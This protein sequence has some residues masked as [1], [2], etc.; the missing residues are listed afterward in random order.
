MF[1]SSLER[2]RHQ[3][4]LKV[5]WKAFELQPREFPPSPEQKAAKERMIQRSWPRVEAM[6]REIYGLQLQRPRLG[7]DTRDAHVAAKATERWNQGDAYHEAL[8]VAYW[9]EGRDIGDREVLTSLAQNLGIDPEAFEAALASE[10][11]MQ[12]VINDQEESRRLGI[13]GVPATLI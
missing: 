7:V 10:E 9:Q 8:F 1:H 12:A 6:A 5:R 2:V 13:G 11:L 3:R 4:V